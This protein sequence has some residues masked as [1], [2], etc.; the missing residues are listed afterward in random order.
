MLIIILFQLTYRLMV[1]MTVDHLSH[2]LAS[3]RRQYGPQ[4][5]DGCVSLDYASRRRL[6][7]PGQSVLARLCHS[8][9]YSVVIRK[10]LFYN[11]SLRRWRNCSAFSDVA[12]QRQHLPYPF[13]SRPHYMHTILWVVLPGD[14]T[15][16]VMPWW[17]FTAIIVI[18]YT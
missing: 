16:R 17:S 3:S 5:G 18:Q 8:N 13:V 2:I 6:V 1:L 7:L 15:M 12:M 11:C 4:T 14:Y 9:R 10:V